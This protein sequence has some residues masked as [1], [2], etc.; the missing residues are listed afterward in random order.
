[1]TLDYFENIYVINLLKRQDRKKH[2]LSELEKIE[3]H[4]FKI[5]EAI[6]GSKEKGYSN[7]KS[8]AIGLANTYFKIYDYFKKA[9]GDYI[10]IIEDDCKFEDDFNQRLDMFLSNTPSDWD[11]LYFGANHN[12]HTGSKTEKINNYCLKLN[13]S[14]SAHS[15]VLKRTLFEKLILN[16]RRSII[17]VDLALSHL[18][19]EHNAY[20][21]TERMTTQIES[22]SDIENKIVNYDWLIK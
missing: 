13:N 6:D 7:I 1:M 18:Q 14:Y 3:C 12:Y 5:V 4:N 2:I 20:S 11:I 22:Y 16:L 8:G 9:S 15:I 19:K 17:E 10:V 21:P